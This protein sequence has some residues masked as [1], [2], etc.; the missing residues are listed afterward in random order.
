MTQPRSALL[1]QIS[2]SLLVVVTAV[3]AGSAQDRKTRVA[4]SAVVERE[5]TTGQRAVGTL[6]PVKVS[7]IGSAVDGRVIEFLVNRG[8]FVKQG[9]PL[10][11]LRTDTLKI[12]R[13][14]ARAELDLRTQELQEMKAGSL[15]QEKLQAESR[16]KAAAASSDFQKS[17]YE[18]TLALHKRGQAATKADLDQA[19]A[20]SIQAEQAL[21][22]VT[23]T[24]DLV[25][26]G[27]RIE[28]IKQA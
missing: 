4:V 16:M 10:A 8:Q 26:A 1:S 20:L 28:K 7:V 18:R 11:E 27:P 3:S 2:L 14:A 15:P 21:V 5:V 6:N 19:L 24:Y 17:K 22:E 9:A 25:K 12:E 23:A 13:A